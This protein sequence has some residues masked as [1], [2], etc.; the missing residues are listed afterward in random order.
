MFD[1]S[2]NPKEE[3]SDE[4]LRGMTLLEVARKTR[5]MDVENHIESQ[6]SDNSHIPEFKRRRFGSSLILPTYG[7]PFTETGMHRLH[8]SGYG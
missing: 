8:V 6:I 4:T 5:S 7:G 1:F 3:T 2:Q